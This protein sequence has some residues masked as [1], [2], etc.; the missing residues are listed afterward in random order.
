LGRLVSSP[1][2]R[3]QQPP[4]QASEGPSRVIFKS[5][6]L[7]GTMADEYFQLAG[8]A[9]FWCRRRFEVLQSL[10]GDL[11]RAAKRPAEIGCGNGVLQRQIE[12]AYGLAPAGFDLHEAALR[13]S[14]SRR[15]EVYCY[16]IVERAEE[17]RGAFDLVF[18]FDVL[19]HIADEDAFLAAA[20]FHLARGG[21]MILNVPALQWLYSE[22]DRVQ[23]HERRYSLAGVKS[24][25]ERNGFRLSRMTYW[26]G[27]LVPLV[28]LRKAMLAIG[29]RRLDN[30]SAGFDAR[31][32][33]LNA[34]LY[35]LSRIEPVPQRSMGTSVMAVLEAYD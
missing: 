34:C 31:G 24:V 35:G 30:Y 13:H 23:G 14:L 19:E 28:A 18:L 22:Y 17:F 26:G 32:A 29:K 12:D 25:A 1:N 27:P 11:L 9:H 16:D 5:K 15:G 7:A 21:A 33:F 8:P 3:A 20:R 2:G 6:P 10:A 4:H